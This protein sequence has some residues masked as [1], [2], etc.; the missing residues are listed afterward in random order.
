MSRILGRI[1]DLKYQGVAGKLIIKPN[2][3]VT[4]D[5]DDLQVVT[6]IEYETPDGELDIVVNETQT[7]NVS[8]NLDFKPLVSSSPNVY[9]DE[10]LKPFPF[11]AVLPPGDTAIGQLAP[12]SIVTD[13][14]AQGA[15]RVARIISTTP[16]YA[17]LVGG[18]EPKGDWVNTVTYSYN[19]L[20]KYNYKIFICKSNTPLT[21]IVPIDGVNWMEIPVDPEGTI[22]YGDDT[23]YGSV[24]NASILPPTQNSVYDKIELLD[25]AKANTT[26]LALK[27]NLASPTFTGNVI[28]PNQTVGDSSTK[29]AN[30]A[31]VAT[32]LALKAD[33]ASPALTGN[34]TATTQATTDNSTRIATTA[35]VNNKLTARIVLMIYRTTDLTVAHVGTW[36]V[37]TYNVT[38]F[39]DGNWN[40]GTNTY[41]VPS[42]GYYKITHNAIVITS[43]GTPPTGSSI[44]TGILLNGTTTIHL[45]GGYFPN[46]FANNS[47]SNI[48]LLTAGNTIRPYLF[49]D[50]F[51]GSGYT[52]TI[53]GAS[54]P[55]FSI[56]KLS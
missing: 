45:G 44:F 52:T 16:E 22:S 38:G 50:H 54:L 11:D 12:T 5:N 55:T 34:P 56:E 9:S 53:I 24:W 25:A 7:L 32:G 29:A 40:S 18:F 46:N 35:L 31:F 17:S 49:Y 48:V 6:T 13:T 3:Y 43:G 8:C 1:I 23:A 47:G 10:S 28:V 36:A 27:A 19:N 21:G 42:T 51:T 26:D 15:L 20:V 14:L 37:P 2:S 30:T 41:T 4:L 39:S 33:L